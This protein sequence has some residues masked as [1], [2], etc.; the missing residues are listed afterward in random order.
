M[1]IREAIRN[2]AGTQQERILFARVVSV[3][4]S[5]KTCDVKTLADEMLMFDVRLMANDGNGVLLVP[6]EDSIVGVSMVNDIEGYVSLFSQIDSIQYGDGTFDG[7]VKVI[8]LV[9]KL[10]ILESDLNDLKTALSGWTPV[11][12]D[13]G[14][15]L[16]AALT[17][18]FSAILTETVKE[19]IGNEKITHGEF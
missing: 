13:G 12:A 2:I 17:S 7:I 19:D 11:P 9:E 10:N 8:D 16:K 5:S 3:D 18:Y 1:T 14:A 15:A 4:N 6:S